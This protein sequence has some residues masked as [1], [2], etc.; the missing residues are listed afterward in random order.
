MAGTLTKLINTSYVIPACVWERRMPW[1]PSG[2]IS[3]I[4]RHRFRSMIKHVWKHVPFYRDAMLER[5]LTPNDFRHTD[6]LKLLPLI[7]NREF[8]KDPLIFNSDTINTDND[9][10]MRAG[11]Y[12]QIFWSRHA[13]LQWFTRIS[14][15]RAVLNNLLEKQ[16]GYVEAY[17]Q[18]SQD[19]NHTLNRYW[20]E[21]L[22]FR[23]MASMRHRLDI[24]DPYEKTIERLNEIKPDIV[25]CYG[26]QTEQVF[27]YIRNHNLDFVPPR[28]WIYGSDMMS[29]GTKRLI[30]EEYG[31]LVYS[32]YNMNET[33]PLS[34]ECEYRDGFHL[35]EDACHARIVDQEGR[36][37]T[38]GTE[39][40]VV[41][42]N[43]VNKATVILNYLTGDRAVM[44]REPCKCGRTLPL[45][46]E[47]QGRV[48]DTIYRADGTTV[49]YAALAP[50]AGSM[51][52]RV[53]DFQV[54]QE[55]PG[56]I[57]W[58]LV[59]FDNSP[60]DEIA[61]ALAEATKRVFPAPDQVDVQWVDR[62][63]LT[64]GHKKNFVVHRF[65]V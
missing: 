7:S 40:E 60:R 38:D 21:N 32:T 11:N 41:I 2:I 10:V 29:P 51:L 65:S 24:N 37:L 53:R 48:C 62:I 22:L 1:M 15:T 58:T 44:S 12:K 34:F 45:I 56:R 55:R 49:S 19:C 17:I 54:V 52:A 59:P 4:Q 33:G 5:G 47:L 46:K 6:D 14:R 20:K 26:S 61:A 8:R 30:E 13:A 27:K 23:G 28:V 25:Y 43:L 39:G 18:P 64:P 36:T 16:T 50:P 57:C 42:S 3:S 9:Y 63:E 35:N 31:C